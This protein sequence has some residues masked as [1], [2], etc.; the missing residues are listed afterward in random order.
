MFLSPEQ[1]IAFKKYLKGNNIF[2]TGPGG[3]G[4]SALIQHIF[5]DAKSKKKNI[6][7]CAM[8]GCAAVLLQC[9]ART[10]HSW[11]GIG[12]GNRPI[13]DII[14]TITNNYF[15]KK[16][17]TRVRILVVD[18][19]S[20]LSLK[21]FNMLNTIGKAIRKNDKAFGGI[22]VIFTGD[23]YQLPPVGNMIDEE[24]R[25]F[26]FESEQW[27]DVFPEDNEIQ[28]RRIYRQT[29]GEYVSLLNGVRVGEI[30]KTMEDIL[31]SRLKQEE[32]NINNDLSVVKLYPIKNKVE[33]INRSEM[34]KLQTQST[35]YNIIIKDNIAGL[36]GDARIKRRA[37]SDTF[38]EYEIQN[39]ISNLICD[40]EILLKVGA[41]VM[42]VVNVCEN[43][44]L[45]LCNG[46]QGKVIGFEK[47][48]DSKLYP[49]VQFNNGCRHT[50]TPHTWECERVPGLVVSQIP[51][52]LSWALTIH[53]SQGVT[54]DY[55]DI[56]V[57]SCVF[58]CGQTYVALSR[59]RTLE[60]L[61]LSSLDLTKIKVNKKVKLYYE[62]LNRLDIEDSKA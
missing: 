17:W 33:Q 1:T 32:H 13:E 57:G 59:V 45:I 26:C 52:I 15:K 56:D 38:I 60:G 51:L 14:Y 24:T 40:R 29:D 8:T 48:D 18:E 35:Q 34:L 10:I 27:E 46:S 30:N 4:K 6:Q 23:F 55:A 47:G 19:V 43:E 31:K 11:S 61:Y 36:I 49:I 37:I 9:D 25:Q 42:C 44:K 50:M 41:H 16:E 12:L 2:I 20:M 39:F 3:S 28:L 62:N 54:L 22:Q 53:K 7:V 21:L 58:E 5:A